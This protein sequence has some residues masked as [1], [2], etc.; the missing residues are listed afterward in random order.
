LRVSIS[1][2][3][4]FCRHCEEYFAPEDYLLHVQEVLEEFAEE[5]EEQGE[6]D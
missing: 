3:L 4:K 1:K 6:E 5:T 2:G